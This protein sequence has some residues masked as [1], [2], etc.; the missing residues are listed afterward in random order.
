[1]YLSW[2]VPSSD[3]GSTLTN[4]S[5]YRSMTSGSGYVKLTTVSSTT[6]HYND[7]SVTNGKIYYYIVKANNALGASSN[8]NEVIGKPTT[9]TATTTPSGTTTTSSS[10]SKSSSESNTSTT[11]PGFELLSLLVL[12]VSLTIFDRKKLK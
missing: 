2:L 8:S 12:L 7:T 3:G 10:S 4:Y 9:S 11:T 1:M 5:I 6:L